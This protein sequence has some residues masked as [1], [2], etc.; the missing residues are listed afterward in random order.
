MDILKEHRQNG[1]YAK[2]AVTERPDDRDFPMH[3]HGSAE[4]YFFVDGKT[5]YIV[6]GTVY[7]LRRGD[8]LLIRPSESHKPRITAGVRYERYNVNF[9]ESLISSVDPEGRLLRPFFDRSL[10]KGNLYRA[11]ELGDLPLE[12]MFYELCHTE[13]DDYGIRLRLL[14]FL[15]RVLERIGEAYDKRGAADY[16]EGDRLSEIV[17]Y[18][19]A[20][21]FDTESVA[22]VAA[23]FY[24]STSQFGRVFKEATGASPWDY[25]KTKRLAAARELIKNGKSASDAAASCGFNDYSAFY[26]SYVKRYGHAPTERGV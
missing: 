3:L 10:G 25:I 24:L 2:H 21:L 14:S 16:D 7:T 9:R 12:R 23:H 19:N 26:R 18:I 13:D 1:I 4:I 17:E 22:E 8:V 20:H 5:D 11:S 6:E 15:L